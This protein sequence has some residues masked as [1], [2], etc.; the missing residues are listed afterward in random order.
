M[1][2]RHKQRLAFVVILL[3]GFAV[4]ASL[5]LYS[6]E[7][8]LLYFYTPAQVAQEIPPVGR[9]FNLGGMVVPGSITRGD[10]VSFALSD[11]RAIT[12]VVY[13]GL[14]PDLFGEGQGAV[15]TGRLREDGVFAADSVLA[16]HD[17]NYMPPGVAETLGKQP[18]GIAA[19]D[20]AAGRGPGAPPAR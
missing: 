8:N 5:V 18:L 14:L 6:L 12:R 15:A 1:T 10:S 20:S 4:A 16:K 7:K 11:D 3:V 2:P 19:P 13:R 9:T 17:E